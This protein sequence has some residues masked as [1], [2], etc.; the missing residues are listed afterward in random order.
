MS[1][2]M[3]SLRGAV[4]GAASSLD[5]SINETT[6]RLAVTGLSRAGKTVFITSLI[7]NLL[8]LGQ[9]HGTLPR[10]QKALERTDGGSR[11]RRVEVV[12]AGSAALPYFDHAAKFAELASDAPSWPSRTEDLATIAVELEL[13]RESSAGRWLGKR[14]IRLDI[15]DYPGEWLLDLPLRGKSFA[16]WSRETLTLISRAP[17]H[18][19]FA[20]FTAFLEA[21]DPLGPAKD[22]LIQRGHSLYRNALNACRV[23][24]GLRYLQPGRFLCPGPRGDVPLMWFFP[25][26]GTEAF[27][28]GSAGAL[29][30]ER[31]E[32]YKAD[33]AASFFDSHLVHFDRQIM[34]VDVLGA[35]HA[36]QGAFEDTAQALAEIAAAL[37]YGLNLPHMVQ[38]VGD[39]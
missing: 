29:L 33:M 24:L 36:G 4:A 22:Q 11:L 5:A 39:E 18:D 20:E 21:F 37:H 12:S 27:P 31:F 25:C 15:L 19:I 35:L 10:V 7:Q 32:A 30:N 16:S 17:R 14:R 34:L 1:G 26:G 23:R 28:R 6:I 13:D 2:F 38:S 3:G 9:G 8:A